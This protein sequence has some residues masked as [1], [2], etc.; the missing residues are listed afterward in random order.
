MTVYSLVVNGD[1]IGT[2]PI[3]DAINT[4]SYKLAKFFVP[5]LSPLVINEYT[6]K[7]SFAFAK[8][9]TKTDYNYIMASLDVE[10]LF[11][12]IPIEETILKIVLM[13][14]FLINLKLII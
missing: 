2:R 5:I 11:T 4:P 9:I 1:K 14:C 13:I 3:I 7:H 12:N 6:V 10:S 8:K